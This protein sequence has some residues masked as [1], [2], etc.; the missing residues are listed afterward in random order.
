MGSEVEAVWRVCEVV[1]GDCQ[2]CPA[3]EERDGDTCVRSCF[4]QA[5][6]CINVVETGNPWRKTEGVDGRWTV[7]SKLR[8]DAGNGELVAYRTAVKEAVLK[9]IEGAQD[10]AIPEPW[11]VAGHHAEIATNAIVA[12]ERGSQVGD[13]WVLVP[14]EPTG[15][16]LE[17][18]FD[19]VDSEDRDKRNE[20]LGWF[21]LA[22]RA[23][24]AAAPAHGEGG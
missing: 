7:L 6:E 4:V 17:A 14:R 13:G 18:V 5:T 8:Q 22:Y 11:E 19:A 21:W 2:H 15:D 9:A 1:R 20:R 16:M 3:T 23:M 24:L 12:L 10:S